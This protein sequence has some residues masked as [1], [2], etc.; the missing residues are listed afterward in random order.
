MHDP[1]LGVP[2]GNVCVENPD[3]VFHSP[4]DHSLYDRAGPLVKVP[5]DY[6]IAVDI[7]R[8]PTDAGRLHGDMA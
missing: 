6:D 1:F 5:G 2:K 3:G 4:N 8:P 7:S